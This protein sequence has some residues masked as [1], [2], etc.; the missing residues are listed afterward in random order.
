MSTVGIEFGSAKLMSY[1]VV[2]RLHERNY[3][4]RY[5]EGFVEWVDLDDDVIIRDAVLIAKLERI[6]QALLFG[7]GK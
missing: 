2:I 5:N 1:N 6:V 4:H 3:M 7:G